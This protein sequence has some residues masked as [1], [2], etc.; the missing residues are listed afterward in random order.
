MPENQT[1]LI[2]IEPNL[3]SP[4]GH[5]ADFVRSLGSCA[6]PGQIAVYADPAADQMLATMSGIRVSL[7]PP[8]VGERLAEWRTIFRLI[9][10]QQPFLVLTADARHAAALSLAAK[11]TNKPPHSAMLFFHRTPTTPRDRLLLPLTEPAKAYAHAVTPTEEVAHWLRTNGWQRVSCIPYPVLTEHPPP[12]PSPF[13]HLLMAGAARINKGLDIVANMSVQ[14]TQQGREIPLLV[15]V[16]TKHVGRHGRREA[17]AVA[18][19]LESG[20]KGLQADESA[21][22]RTEYLARFKG[23]LVLAP[24]A[25]EQFASQVSGVVLD[26]L[27]HG[28]PVIATS[29]TWPGAQIERFGAGLTIA[30]RTPDALSD[31]I[32]R[33]LADWDNY[34]ARACEAGSTLAEEHHPSRLLTALLHIP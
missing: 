12:T 13:R 21:P 26:A 5:Y 15:Q 1:D 27:L 18:T 10:D 33:I 14:W 2:I 4:S 11:V 7:Q 24:Y 31:A 20:Y 22:D 34:A 30:E 28:A 17:G 23:A 25:R 16:S 32:D 19:L 3:R 9:T 6:E 8:R 29:G